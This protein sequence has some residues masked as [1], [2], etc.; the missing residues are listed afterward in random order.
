MKILLRDLSKLLALACLLASC[1]WAQRK[2]W[3]QPGP[4][5]LPLQFFLQHREDYEVVD[6]RTDTE[7]QSGHIPGAVNLPVSLAMRQR[8]EGQSLLAHGRARPVLIYCDGDSC[9]ASMQVGSWL[10][11]QG[12]TV[13]ILAG[14]YPGWLAAQGKRL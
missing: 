12:Y 5:S 10:Q 14:G 3:Q 6:A 1:H 7:F 9:N 4:P 13:Q 11:E 2:L 8:R